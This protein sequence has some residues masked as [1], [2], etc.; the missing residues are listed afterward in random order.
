MVMKVLITIFCVMTPFSS[1]GV[2]KRF[3]NH[4]AAVCSILKP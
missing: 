2:G 4:T 3:R 1:V